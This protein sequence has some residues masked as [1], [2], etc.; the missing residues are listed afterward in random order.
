MNIDIERYLNDEMSP[1]ERA[2]F[3]QN[4]EQDPAMQAELEQAR[5]LLARLKAQ[6]LRERVQRALAADEAASLPTVTTS[7][8]WL[9]IPLVLLLPVAATMYFAGRDKDKE[10][11]I[12]KDEKDPEDQ[13]SIQTPDVMPEILDESALAP[14]IAQAPAL[15]LPSGPSVRGEGEAPDNRE[16][17]EAAI[18]DIPF[19]PK[20]EAYNERF[21]PALR[22]LMEKSFI[23]AFVQLQ[24]LELQIPD[25]DTLAFLKGYNL[26]E[27]GEGQEALRYFGKLPPGSQWE[28]EVAWYSILAHLISGQARLAA[29]K[30]KV[31]AGDPSHPF[32]AEA[33]ALL[34]QI[35]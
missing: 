32:R 13:D 30:A 33:R 11:T 2:Q 15:I 29:A 7:K 18:G 23:D 20:Q 4:T 19:E 1:E 31:I 27:L 21:A 10:T 6:L 9:W 12:S 25:N 22:L 3:E 28:P 5:A 16:K 14:P 34:T 35:E 26:L 17:L 24:L 8:R